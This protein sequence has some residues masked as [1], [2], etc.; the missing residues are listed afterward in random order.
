MKKALCF[1]LVCLLLPVCALAEI[2]SGDWGKEVQEIQQL[3]PN[4]TSPS[5]PI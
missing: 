5:I 4:M 3:F 2:Q 1:M